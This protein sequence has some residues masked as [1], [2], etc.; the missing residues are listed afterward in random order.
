MKS[1]LVTTALFSSGCFAIGGVSSNLIVSGTGG[2][3]SDV[4]VATAIGT[5]VG[6]LIDGVL[7]LWALK[8][9]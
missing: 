2:S 7:I 9:H 3:R 5:T 8:R 4:T 1:I 6:F